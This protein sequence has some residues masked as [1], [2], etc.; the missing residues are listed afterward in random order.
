MSIKDD[1][2]EALLSHPSAAGRP[3]AASQ[4]EA[5]GF[6]LEKVLEKHKVTQVKEIHN[7]YHPGKNQTLSAVG[8]VVRARTDDALQGWRN[9][10]SGSR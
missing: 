8:D 2:V 6:A 3:L 5:F 9:L 1:F 10:T 4:A 7:H